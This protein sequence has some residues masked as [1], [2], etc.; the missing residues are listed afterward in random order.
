VSSQPCNVAKDLNNLA[1]LLKATNR[2]AEAEPL[3]RR[4][5]KIVEQSFGENHPDVAR[6][7]NNLAQLL[8]ATNRLAEAEPLM[9]RALKINEKSFG[10]NHPKVARDLNN[11]A[12]LLKATNRLDEAEPLMRRAFL[13]FKQSLGMQHPNT[14]NVLNNYKILL[15]TMGRSDQVIRSD[16]EKLGVQTGTEPSPKLRAVIEQMNRDPSKAQDIAA[17]LQREDPALFMELL[18]LI[19]SQ[20]QE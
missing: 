18:E 14:Q 17:K 12:Q 13:I 4:A 11:L 9:R 1:Q 19:Q 5:L 6:D 7:L 15:Q 10:E 3:I 2:L 20:Q 16:L 8:K